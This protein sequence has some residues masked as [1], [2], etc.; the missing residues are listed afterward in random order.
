M[1]DRG[2]YQHF[3]K[4][5]GD[6]ALVRHLPKPITANH[7]QTVDA[8]RGFA[9]LG[10]FVVNIQSYLWGLT[11]PMMGVIDANSS[12]WDSVAL[13]LVATVFEYKT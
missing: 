12:V 13:L 9:L 1:F 3:F 7:S 8:L 11:G 6:I 2:L 4:P 10:I 5:C